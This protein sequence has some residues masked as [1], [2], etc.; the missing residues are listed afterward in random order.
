MSKLQRNQKM[1]DHKIASGRNTMPRKSLPTAHTM[2][3]R[4]IM[5]AASESQK[6][7]TQQMVGFHFTSLTWYL[8][9]RNYLM[10]N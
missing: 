2:F 10:I 7:E 4:I 3:A 6:H 9:W 8:V 1:D 5:I